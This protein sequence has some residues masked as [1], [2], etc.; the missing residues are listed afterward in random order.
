MP[1]FEYKCIKCGRISEFL[2]PHDSK[3][4]KTCRHCGGKKLEKQF[5]TFAFKIKEGDSKRCGGCGDQ[6]CPHSGH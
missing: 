5:S 2:E 1:I 4:L 3:E 6:S